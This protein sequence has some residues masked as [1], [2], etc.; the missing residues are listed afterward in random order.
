MET[1]IPADRERLHDFAGAL[2]D[3]LDRLDDVYRGHLARIARDAPY[4]GE[5]KVSAACAELVGTRECRV[6]RARASMELEAIGMRPS[7]G[8]ARMPEVVAG[9]K[10]QLNLALAVVLPK[11]LLEKRRL[12]MRV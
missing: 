8:A 5:A 7:Q 3:E 2:R 11:S 10:R 6:F 1:R 4:A 9:G 12:G